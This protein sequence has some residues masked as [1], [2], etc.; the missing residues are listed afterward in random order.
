L[1]GALVGFVA[2]VGGDVDGKGYWL[3]LNLDS[4]AGLNAF[5]IIATP[6]RP[7]KF[8][9]AD[10]LLASRGL[11]DLCDASLAP[12][13]GEGQLMVNFYHQVIDDVPVAL[14][15]RRAQRDLKRAYPGTRTGARS[16]VRAI[17][18]LSSAKNT[19]RYFE[20]YPHA[21]I[22]SSPYS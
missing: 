9:P 11:M 22:L 15:L 21:A 18:D 1:A 13:I 6:C 5:A 14:A 8:R 4:F 19:F 3:D 7:Q 10:N 16:S 17:R 12:D 20:C 2:G